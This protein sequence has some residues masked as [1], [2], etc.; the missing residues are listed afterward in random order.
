MID[1]SNSNPNFSSL[2][3]SQTAS[4]LNV[5]LSEIR[6]QLVAS[7]TGGIYDCGGGIIRIEFD[8]GYV[9][10]LRTKNL[11]RRLDEV[12]RQLMAPKLGPSTEKWIKQIR[13]GRQ[14]FT[15][16]ELRELNI[17]IRRDGG[18]F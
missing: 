2:T 15:F 8:N 17:K 7:I 9:H 5:P 10:K 12:F 11:A 3:D 13:E 1:N 18:I 4:K 6:H 16:E 14:Q